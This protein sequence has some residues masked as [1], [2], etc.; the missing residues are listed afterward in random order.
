MPR[1]SMTVE[2]DEEEQHPAVHLVQVPR[3]SMTVEVDEEEQ[4]PA[5]HQVQVPRE[6]MTVEVGQRECRAV[7]LG[8]GR[9]VLDRAVSQM[10]KIVVAPEAGL[11]SLRQLQVAL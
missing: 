10:D 9:T 8:L 11:V 5:V 2:V 6:S 4:H 7:I 1:E 3:E